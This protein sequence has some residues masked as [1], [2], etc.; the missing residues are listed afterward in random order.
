MEPTIVGRSEAEK[1]ACAPA[2]ARSD[3]AVRVGKAEARNLNVIGCRT[4]QA[5]YLAV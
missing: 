2:L 3:N 4:A 5:R 1:L